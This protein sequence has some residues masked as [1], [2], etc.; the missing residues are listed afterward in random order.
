MSQ[1][2][3][4]PF[5]LSQQNATLSYGNTVNT[6]TFSRDLARDRLSLLGSGSSGST[7]SLDS[8]LL[9]SAPISLFSDTSLGTLSS[10][11]ADSPQRHAYTQLAR[12]YQQAQDELKEVNTEYKRLKYVHIAFYLHTHH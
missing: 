1:S 4:P 11:G 2:D 3:F 6:P 5:P 7:V 8:S 9:S 10:F 12:Q